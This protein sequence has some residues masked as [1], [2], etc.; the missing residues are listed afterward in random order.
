MKNV[1]SLKL[2]RDIGLSLPAAWFMLHR[3]REGWTR[4]EEST[5]FTRPVELDETYMGGKRKNVP[6]SKRKKLTGDSPRG[7]SAIVGA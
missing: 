5:K 7:K 1:S 4:C 6:A 3:I 2:H